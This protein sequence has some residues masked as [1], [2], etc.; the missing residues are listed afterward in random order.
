MKC[1]WREDHLPASPDGLQVVSHLGRPCWVTL[2]PGFVFRGRITKS[3]GYVFGRIGFL[4]RKY[5]C[6]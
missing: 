6:S 1:N 3:A 2:G 5:E 4:T